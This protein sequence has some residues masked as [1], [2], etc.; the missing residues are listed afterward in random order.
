MKSNGPSARK[1][2]R[3]EKVRTRQLRLLVYALERFDG[4]IGTGRLRQ[5]EIDTPEEQMERLR[6]ILL[7]EIRRLDPEHIDTPEEHRAT[8]ATGP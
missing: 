4:V 1:V 8:R 5:P 3:E 2:H 7:S 6:E